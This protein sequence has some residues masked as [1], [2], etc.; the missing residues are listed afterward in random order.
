[1]ISKVRSLESRL[2]VAYI[3]IKEDIMVKLELSDDDADTLEPVIARFLT[4]IKREITRTEARDYRNELKK[5]EQALKG[6]AEKLKN[7]SSRC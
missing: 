2:L 6:V 4:E 1:M 7:R 3:Q 5:E